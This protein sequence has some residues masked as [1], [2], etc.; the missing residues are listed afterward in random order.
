[1]NQEEKK[2]FRQKILAT[3]KQVRVDIENLEELTKPIPPE[4]S[5][6][7]VSRMDAINNKSVNEANLRRSRMKLTRLETA[8][9]KLDLPKFGIC[10]RCNKPIKAARLM[11]MPESTCCVRCAR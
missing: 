8:L 7:R 2:A 1:M 9:Q 10:T 4:N 5:I 11:Y 6:G 3:L